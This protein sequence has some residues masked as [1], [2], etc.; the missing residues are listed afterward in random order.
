MLLGSQHPSS[1]SRRRGQG[2]VAFSVTQPR[3]EVLLAPWQFPV[4]ETSG[5]SRVCNDVSLMSLI[6]R[7][8]ALS[9]PPL[10]LSVVA[11]SALTACGGQPNDGSPLPASECV[12]VETSLVGVI[13][14]VYTHKTWDETT[15]VLTAVRSAYPSFDKA[16]FTSQWRYDSAGRLITFTSVS[17][18]ET[19]Q[20]DWAYDDHKRVKERRLSYPPAPDLFSPSL[21]ETWDGSSYDSHYDPA[22]HLIDSTEALLGDHS[23]VPGSI[24]WV[25]QE[26][27][28]GRCVARDS[29]ENQLRAKE[30]RSYDPQG[31][32]VQ[33]QETSTTGSW[34]T[35][36]TY[37][38]QGRLQTETSTRSM[39][40]MPSPYIPDRSGTVTTSY[41]FNADGSETVTVEDE[42]PA[43]KYDPHHVTQRRAACLAIDSAMAIPEDAHC[44]TNRDCRQSTTWGPHC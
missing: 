35:T 27:D 9:I 13:P 24:Q 19:T 15:R 40:A 2:S 14:T 39:S 33:I 34:I 44:Q 31:R 32:L 17:L 7:L 3:K 4:R 25:Y 41:A 16:N 21:A 30:Q 8:A 42:T 36:R 12:E 20:E 29:V 6:A 10:W 38:D 18:G 43:G 22:G 5:W 37:D 23:D 1:T 26:D 28:A 11:V